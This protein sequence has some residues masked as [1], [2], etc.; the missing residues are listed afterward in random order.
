[1][2]SFV[3]M[4]VVP[5][6]GTGIRA[7]R[8]HMPKY[9]ATALLCNGPE[10]SVFCDIAELGMA[11]LSSLVSTPEGRA[12]FKAEDGEKNVLQWTKTWNKGEETRG[13]TCIVDGC[14]KAN[15]VQE[16]AANCIDM[17]KR[18]LRYKKGKKK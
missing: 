15:F 12:A 4:K 2:I 13:R 18:K 17:S 8:G 11:L 7:A 3:V 1:M 14:P 5:A 16:A 9:T 6:V 10:C